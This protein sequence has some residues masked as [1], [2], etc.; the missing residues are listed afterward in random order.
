M[1]DYRTRVTD[2]IMDNNQFRQHVDC[3]AEQLCQAVG[4]RFNFRVSTPSNDVV[5][6]KLS[7]LCNFLLE[8][9]S[10]QVEE[11]KEHQSTLE[12]HIKERTARLDLILKGAAVA[13]IEIDLQQNML[14]ISG[15]H[16]VIER[17]QLKNNQTFTVKEWLR[18]IHPSDQKKIR[19][20]LSQY[21]NGRIPHM[22]IEYRQKAPSAGYYYMQFHGVGNTPP[23]IP[24][25][26]IAGTLID[27]TH[28]HYIDDT[29]GL[30][31]LRYFQDTFADEQRR[32][33]PIVCFMI[34]VT[35]FYAL[36][37]TF[38][39]EFYPEF[40]RQLLTRLRLNQHPGEQLI[41]L[42]NGQYL[43]MTQR[44]DFS[45][46]HQRCQQITESLNQNMVLNNQQLWLKSHVVGIDTTQQHF[47]TAGEI[48][49]AAQIVLRELGRHNQDCYAFYNDQYRKNAKLRQ[50]IEHYIRDAILNDGVHVYLQPVVNLMQRRITGYEALTRIE[51]P[52]MGVI[53]PDKFIPIAE[54]T[55]LIEPLSQLIFNKVIQLLKD[56]RL[57][58]LHPPKK[59]HVIGINISAILLNQPYLPERLIQQLHKAHITPARLKIEL[60]ESGVMHDTQNARIL[61]QKFRDHHMD[62]ALDDFGTGYSSL[63]YLRN[64]PFSTIKLDR[65]I[66]TGITR[67]QSQSAIVEM[68]IQLAKKMGLN[69]IVEGIETV[70]ELNYICSIGGQ[71]AQGFLFSKPVPVEKIADVHRHILSIWPQM[72][73][74][75]M[76]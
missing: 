46:L 56:P 8:S 6:Q 43:L 13:I 50:T 15:D 4:Q 66:I 31:N 55:G 42:E 9:A 3:I 28:L 72:I 5:L 18:Q 44:D 48:L 53:A 67:D 76:Q 10:R 61:L 70:H 16:R 49:N 65:Q 19:R 35:N 29:S 7:Y 63:A 20:T 41:A 24:P 34:A 59:P 75:Q 58:A 30:A 52:L 40:R 38:P 32:G 37:E 54:D 57:L 22:N 64:L 17:A 12:K 11:S 62:V 2:R 26:R 51:H 33:T 25:T 69:V 73:W 27:Q 39:R 47:E 71:M 14:Q 45:I 21:L 68:V 36:L 1:S 60:T 23:G 74:P